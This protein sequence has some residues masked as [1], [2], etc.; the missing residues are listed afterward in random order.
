MS[1]KRTI[2][3]LGCKVD[4]V[5]FGKRSFYYPQIGD[6]EFRVSSKGFRQLSQFIR[7]CR[8]LADSIR[9][10]GQ[11]IHLETPEQP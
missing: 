4:V 2:E 7:T 1:A 6:Q 5:T 11:I 9:E 10:I 3:V 8:Y